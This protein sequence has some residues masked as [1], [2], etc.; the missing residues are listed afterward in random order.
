[1]KKLIDVAKKDR[2]VGSV[3]KPTLQIASRDFGEPPA[4]LV[5]ATFADRVQIVRLSQSL[6]VTRIAT[7]ATQ[8]ATFGSER[9]GWRGKDPIAQSWT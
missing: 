2:P 1:M 9:F 7:N 5:C 4:G 6:R 3:L 8:S